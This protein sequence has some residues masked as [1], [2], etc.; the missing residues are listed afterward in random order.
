[1]RYKFEAFDKKIHYVQ[2]FF[3]RNKLIIKLRFLNLTMQ[4]SIN[5]MS[6]TTFIKRKA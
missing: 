4:V 6:S 5:F 1:M 3:K 2:K